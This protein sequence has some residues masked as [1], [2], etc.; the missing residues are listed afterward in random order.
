MDEKAHPE[1]PRGEDLKRA[2]D[3]PGDNC[4]TPIPNRIHRLGVVFHPSSTDGY[5]NETF[6]IRFAIPP[7]T[8]LAAGKAGPGTVRG[9]PPGWAAPKPCP[10]PW[11]GAPYARPGPVDGGMERHRQ[12]PRADFPRLCLVLFQ[13]TFSETQLPRK[14]HVAGAN[15]GATVRRRLQD[16]PTWPSQRAPHRSPGRRVIGAYFI[17]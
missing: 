7:G 15:C 3:D 9:G 16:G 13:R 5:P 1:C 11:G 8:A 17:A 4:E 14:H 6:A 12:I 10:A 2:R